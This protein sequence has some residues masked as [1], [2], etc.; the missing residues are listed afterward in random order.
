MCVYVQPVVAAPIAP[1][2]L[3]ERVTARSGVAALVIFA[4]LALA[5]WGE[6]I[7]GRRL[8]AAYRPPAEGA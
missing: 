4:G 6:E 1:L 7:A 8:G 5:T 3:G 2:V